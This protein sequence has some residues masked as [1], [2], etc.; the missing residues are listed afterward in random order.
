MLCKVA[1]S[2][3]RLQLTAT[4]RSKP[5]ETSRNLLKHI[6]FI[7]DYYARKQIEFS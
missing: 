2:C 6:I 5:N 4:S 1:V 7:G 3:E